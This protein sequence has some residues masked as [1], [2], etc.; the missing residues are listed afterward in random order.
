MAPKAPH[1]ATVTPSR[2]PHPAT[3]AQP[4]FM[5]G[6]PART[7]HPATVVQR[8]AVPHPA[9]LAAMGRS[10]QRAQENPD[11]PKDT[12]SGASSAAKEADDKDSKGDPMK[13]V[14]A[15]FVTLIEALVALNRTGNDDDANIAKRQHAVDTALD[16]LEK[17]FRKVFLMQKVGKTTKTVADLIAMARGPDASLLCHKAFSGGLLLALL[18]WQDLPE[19]AQPHLPKA[20]LVVMH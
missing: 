16:G 18:S 6:A 5:S 12:K 15:Q 3:V 4:R 13:A 17:G 19:E 11:P 10:V 1:L 8:R 9:T 7:P 2:A 14:T 20:H